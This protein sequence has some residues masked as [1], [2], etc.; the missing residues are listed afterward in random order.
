MENASKALIIAGGI[1]IAIALISLALYLFAS[2]RGL[3]DASNTVLEQSQIESFNR[4]YLSYAPAFGTYYEISG[5]DANNV[6][7]KVENDN[8]SEVV[9][10]EIYLNTTLKDE[11]KTPENFFTNYKIKVEDLNGD[12]AIDKITITK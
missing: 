9:Y 7:R 5:L 12:T 11:V 6:I 1:L 10:S 8:N 4:F 3:V 2:A